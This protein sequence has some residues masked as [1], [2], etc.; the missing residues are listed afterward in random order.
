LE[1]EHA[2]FQA[3]EVEGGDV[4]VAQLLP[5]PALPGGSRGDILRIIPAS[6]YI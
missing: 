5:D 4:T 1:A 2:G 6:S 3:M